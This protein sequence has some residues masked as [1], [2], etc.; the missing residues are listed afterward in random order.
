MAGHKWPEVGA[1]ACLERWGWQRQSDGGS[2]AGLPG[3]PGTA[4]RTLGL[5]RRTAKETRYVPKNISLQSLENFFKS[6]L[7]K[8]GK[9]ENFLQI[10]TRFNTC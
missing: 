1:D 3:T 8:L 2:P 4:R 7:T 10:F 6:V 9:L 5:H